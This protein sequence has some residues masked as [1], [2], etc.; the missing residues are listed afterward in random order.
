MANINVTMTV[1]TTMLTP[2]CSEQT[3]EQACTLSDDSGDPSGHQDFTVNAS[4]GDT[5]TFLIAAVDGV[6]PVAY[7]AFRYEGGDSAVFSEL[8]SSA[9][10]W[11]GTVG[12]EPTGSEESYYID[13]ISNGNPY[14]LD[15]RII[16]DQG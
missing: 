10:G 2:G 7:S 3:I 4:D 8:P 14:T 16:I 11:V 9:N 13:F 5:V 1:D 15:P 12:N 6:T